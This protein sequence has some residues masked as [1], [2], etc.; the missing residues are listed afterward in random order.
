MKSIVAVLIFASAIALRAQ[1]NYIITTKSNTIHGTVKILSY[2]VMDRVSVSVGGRKQNFTAVQVLT[3]HKDSAT[4]V[5]VQHDKTIRFMQVLRSGYLS[6]YGYRQEGQTSYDSRLLA[7][8][9]GAKLDVPNIG[10]KRILGDFL[11]DCE[12]TSAKVKEGEFERS[13]LEAIVDDY[14][15]CVADQNKISHAIVKPT[16]AMEA[17]SSLRTKVERSSLESKKDV[18]DMLNDIE[19]RLRQK[20][21][22]PT[23]LTNG[24][25]SSLANQKDFEEDLNKLLAE[26]D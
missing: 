19:G 15:S 12:S 6:L 22:I 13:N 9:N 16:P 10:F 17:V 1:T 25:K 5:P 8:M 18:V 3:L 11:Q 26:L 24:L 21:T 14:N 2:D 7:K 4:Y 20:Q 23:Y